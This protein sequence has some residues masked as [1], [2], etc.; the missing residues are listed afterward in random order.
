MKFIGP[1][2]SVDGFWQHNFHNSKVTLDLLMGPSSKFI[3]LGTICP[4]VAN[5]MGGKRCSP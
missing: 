4:I 3:S 1:L 2:L 5:L